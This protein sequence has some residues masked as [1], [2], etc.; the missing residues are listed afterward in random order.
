MGHNERQANGVTEKTP[1]GHLNVAQQKDR[2]SHD[3]QGG[4]G[5]FAGRCYPNGAARH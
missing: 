4:V 2:A 3:L 5:I 1:D